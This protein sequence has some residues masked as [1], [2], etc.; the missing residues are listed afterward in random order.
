MPPTGVPGDELDVV[1]AD[2][3]AVNLVEALPHTAVAAATAGLYRVHA[4][5]R[6]TI[7]KVL[8]PAADAPGFW[9]PGGSETHWYYWRREAEAYG[10]GMLATLGGGLRAPR[11]LGVFERADGT[12][13]LW[14]EDLRGTAAPAWPVA[15]YGLAA[16][17]LGRAQGEFLSGRPLPT[18]PWLSRGW[19]RTYVARR[20]RVAGAR[21]GAVDPSVLSDPAA[22]RH[23]A[24]AAWVADPPI[25][26]LRAMRADQPR[27]LDV[28]DRLPLT[29]CHLDLHPA[30]LFDG[31]AGAGTT[32]A[33]IDWSF[34]GIG[35]LGEDAGDLVP[36]A[37]FDLHVRPDHLAD[38]YDAVAAGYDAGLRDA[39]WSGPPEMV[40]LAMAAAMAAKYVWIAPALARAVSDERDQLNGRPTAQ[41]VAAWAPTVRFLL[42]RTEEAR[43]LTRLV[44]P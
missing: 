7:V 12:V 37:V 4:D 3:S 43:E 23:P 19:L 30:N 5:G 27:F 11:C 9:R 34:A 44:V 29:L 2:R 36:D 21:G 39:A 28:L 16:R 15:R 26:A 17:H 31:G 35:A 42:D 20:D 24:L 18:Q 14:L 1:F 10:S 32:T 33:V 6:T 22:W 38:L 41:T 25:A 8:A 40:R 13:A